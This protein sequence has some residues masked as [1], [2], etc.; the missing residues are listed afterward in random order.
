MF[1]AGD[2]AE[3]ESVV[4]G[5]APAADRALGCRVQPGQDGGAEHAR[6]DQPHDV[7]PYF[8]SDLADWASLEYVGPALS[9]DTEVIRG[10]IDDGEFS[11]WYLDRDGRVEAALSVG[12]SDDL[13]HARRLIASEASIGGQ[14]IAALGDPASD[15]AEI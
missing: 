4:H 12:R 11:V 15:L 3:Y 5:G 7:V 9:W 2:I 1:A 8:F 10:S 13:E 6:R 14:G